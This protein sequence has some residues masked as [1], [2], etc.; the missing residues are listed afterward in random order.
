[1]GDEGQMRGASNNTGYGRLKYKCK[2][3]I[4]MYF[5]KM[6]IEF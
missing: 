3:I 5:K 6:A 1:V 4:S 2:E